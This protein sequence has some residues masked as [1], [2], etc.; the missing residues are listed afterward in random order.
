MLELKTHKFILYACGVQ[1]LRKLI[2]TQYSDL[3][4]IDNSINIELDFTVYTTE[5]AKF[6]IGILYYN[7]L[8]YNT[9]P[10]EII[11]TIDTHLYH[12]HQLSL[13]FQFHNLTHFCLTRFYDIFSTEHFTG[14]M[15]YC[16]IRNHDTRL[17]YVPVEKIDLFTRLI[18]WF[19]YCIDDPLDRHDNF[20][21]IK[22]TSQCVATKYHFLREQERVIENFHQLKLP[23]MIIY[24]N[25]TRLQ[26]YRRMCS[27]CLSHPARSITICDMGFIGNE[28][29]KYL[30]YALCKVQDRQEI[31]IIMKREAPQ[32]NSITVQTQVKL[33]S[34]AIDLI[35]K[36]EQSNGCFTSPTQIARLVLN[37]HDECY[38]ATC[39]HC[40]RKEPVFIIDLSLF[41]DESYRDQ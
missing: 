27:N 25:D 17:F 11:T 29:V 5:I 21:A 10:S 38:E 18:Q 35:E 26:Y 20:F 32:K 4:T 39:D 40:H 31:T 9:L 23:T 16:L 6:F 15:E 34:K 1:S 8:D 7:K 19:V 36:N 30:F 3:N 37:S 41:I 2:D 28:R 24:D 33:F 22:D 13:Y 14:I 12:F